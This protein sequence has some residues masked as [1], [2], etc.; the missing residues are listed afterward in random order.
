MVEDLEKEE[1]EEENLED[2][3]EAGNAKTMNKLVEEDLEE[4]EENGGEKESVLEEGAKRGGS[5]PNLEII[6][7]V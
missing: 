6:F 2:A 4:E 7:S 1:G 3:N 5:F